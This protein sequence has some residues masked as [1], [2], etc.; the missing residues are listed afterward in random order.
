ML[1]INYQPLLLSHTLKTLPQP[2]RNF[3]IG[4]MP[5]QKYLRQT[6][7]SKPSTDILVKSIQDSYNE[8]LM[9]IRNTEGTQDY[10][11]GNL[12]HQK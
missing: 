1:R 12:P 8:K 11:T 2:A 5:Q 4:A 3:H 10:R 6:T 7:D 9:E